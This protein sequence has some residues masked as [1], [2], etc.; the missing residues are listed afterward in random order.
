MPNMTDTTEHKT[1]VQEAIDKWIETPKSYFNFLKQRKAILDHPEIIR[2]SSTRKLDGW[3]KPLAYTLKGAALMV[4]LVQGFV[5]LLSFA[6]SNA[7]TSSSKLLATLQTEAADIPIQIAKLQQNRDDMS[8]APPETRFSFIDS[9]DTLSQDEAVAKTNRALST[10]ADRES[11]LQSAIHTLTWR[12]RIDTVWKSIILPVTM[13]LAAFACRRKIAR[14]GGDSS[15]DVDSAYL[16]LS[17][18][19]SLFPNI[20]GGLLLVLAAPVMASAQGWITVLFGLC[21]CVSGLWY[22]HSLGV[23]GSR[24]SDVLGITDT[25]GRQKVHAAV[26]SANL[27]LVIASQMSYQIFSSFSNAALKNLG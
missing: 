12:G 20:L 14:L 21:L 3:S 8:A 17:T 9:P 22:W 23:V 2:S 16:Y 4:L 13:I 7:Y 25:A 1:P 26:R 6:T 10:L 11:A 15:S 18:S 24:L 27:V 5:F 19:H